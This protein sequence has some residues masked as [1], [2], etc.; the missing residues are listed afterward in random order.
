MQRKGTELRRKCRRRFWG[1]L[2]TTT[3]L[4]RK[5]ARSEMMSYMVGRV[6]GQNRGHMKGVVHLLAGFF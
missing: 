2:V 6:G 4:P 5:C 1:I 3:N